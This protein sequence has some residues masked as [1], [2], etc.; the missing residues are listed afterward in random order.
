MDRCR[1]STS[2]LR[3]AHSYHSP[4]PSAPES[5]ASST[6]VGT[7]PILA[8]KD[9]IEDDPEWTTFSFDELQARLERQRNRST[10]VR[11][12]S[13]EEVERVLPPGFTTPNRVV[14][15]LVCLG[16]Q[17]ELAAAWETL[18]ANLLDREQRQ[19]WTAS[20]VRACSGSRPAA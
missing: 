2:S 4:S 15:N 17:P 20:S 3:R 19:D 8:G 7:G 13:W 11:V 1:R 6:D 12:P 14:W 9:L 5:A 18:P 16:H 10:R